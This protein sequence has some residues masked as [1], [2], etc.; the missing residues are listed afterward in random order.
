[1]KIARRIGVVFMTLALAGCGGL[2]AQPARFEAADAAN[3]R[4][5]E[6]F[7]RGEHAVALDHARQAQAMAASIEYESGFADAQINLSIIHGRLG[8]TREAAAAAQAI[9]AAGE[10]MPTARRAEAALRL[11]ILAIDGGDTATATQRL[12]EAEAQCVSPCVL[13]GKLANA[14][15]HLAL[16]AGNTAEALQLAATGQQINRDRADREELANSLR[17]GANAELLAGRPAGIAAPLRE[18]LEIDKQLALPRKIYR[19]LVLLGLAARANGEQQA[20]LAYL[21]RAADVA[22]GDGDAAAV[23]EVADLIDDFNKGNTK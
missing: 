15:A 9:L 8:Q 13:A 22:R 11:A 19:D 21:Q 3:R 5:A 12:A 7:A 16:K 1:M 23:R 4:A 6:S 18:A 10:R 14:R 2:P 20:A 17:L